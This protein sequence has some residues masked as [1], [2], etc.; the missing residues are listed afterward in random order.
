VAGTP[1]RLAFDADTKALDVG[2]VPERPDGA[3]SDKKLLTAISLP[4]RHYPQG[5]TVQAA[6][7]HVT[8]EP[9]AEV[10]LIRT[11]PHAREVSVHVEPG[12]RGAKR[13]R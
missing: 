3:R 4:A 2:F 11:M 5:Y 12:G 7:A 10:L 8:S 6:G 1:T 13:C 9:C